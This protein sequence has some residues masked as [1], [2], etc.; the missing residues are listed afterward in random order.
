MDD[1]LAKKYI[2][3]LLEYQEVKLKC[4]NLGYTRDKDIKIELEII[5]YCID[6]MKK[7]VKP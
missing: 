3:K 2:I 4:L 7:K 1:E 5:E 6:Y